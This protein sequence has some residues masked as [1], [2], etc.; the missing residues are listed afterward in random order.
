MD[1]RSRIAD[2]LRRPG[3][4]GLRTFEQAA[5]F[6]TGFDAATEWEMLKGFQEWL[7]LEVGE[8]ENLAWPILASRL[9]RACP[10]DCPQGCGCEGLADVRMAALFHALRRFLNISAE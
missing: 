4:Y 7:A 9:P 3:A 8:G 10:S 5:A 6:M 2:V 1:S